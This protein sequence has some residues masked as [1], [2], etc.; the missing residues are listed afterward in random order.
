MLQE[1]SSQIH[2]E[3]IKQDEDLVIKEIK[4]KHS[5]LVLGFASLVHFI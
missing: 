5:P 3:I 1:D 2:I 4:I